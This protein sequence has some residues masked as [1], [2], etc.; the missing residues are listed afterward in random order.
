MITLIVLLFIAAIVLYSDI[1]TTLA[2][3]LFAAG[4]LLTIILIFNHKGK[5]A[6]ENTE[7]TKPKDKKGCLKFFVW[8][9]LLLFTQ[10][11]SLKN[12]IPHSETLYLL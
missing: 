10:F 4:I 5:K 1:D 9:A 11:T 8:T 7:E 2:T 12:N 3:I 6:L